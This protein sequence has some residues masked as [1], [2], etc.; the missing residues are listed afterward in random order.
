MDT[1]V[2]LISLPSRSPYHEIIVAFS[3]RRYKL[4]VTTAVL[5]EYEE[6]LT[7][8]AS[9]VIAEN[10]LAAF[11]EAPNLVEVDIYFHWN[12]I[13]ADPDDNKFTDA[14]INGNADYLVTNDAHFNT[15]KS[16]KFPE[17]KILSVDEFLHLLQEG[18]TI[19][20]PTQKF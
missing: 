4:V 13:P 18:R 5:L 7:E 10:V 15:A 12:M 8:K 3:E 1:N 20:N 6:I 17:V 19:H 11:R 14:Y 16:S 2:L 9:Q